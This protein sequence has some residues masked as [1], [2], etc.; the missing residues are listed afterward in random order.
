MAHGTDLGAVQIR[1]EVIGSIAAL[2]AREVDGVMGVWKGLPL[3]GWL[4]GAGSGVRVQIQE[5]EAKIWIPLVV[6]YGV[7]L[8]H[9]AAQVQDKVREAVEQMTQLAA[10]EVN[11][12]IQQIKPRRSASP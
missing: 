10:V 9:V 6:E 11:V 3:P 2:A 8:P 5:V 4:G 7:N 1:N 12:R